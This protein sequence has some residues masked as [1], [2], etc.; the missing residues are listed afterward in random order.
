VQN[1]SKKLREQE[2]KKFLLLAVLTN[3][4][5]ALAQDFNLVDV[6][7][8]PRPL[9]QQLSGSTAAMV[10]ATKL[11]PVTPKV[12]NNIEAYLKAMAIYPK[13]A[14]AS[15]RQ[16][17]KVIKEESAQADKFIPL[18][19]T[20]QEQ[21]YCEDFTLAQEVGLSNCSGTLISDRHILTAGHCADVDLMCE[22]Y[23]WVFDYQKDATNKLPES[24]SQE[25]VYRCKNIVKSINVNI[26]TGIMSQIYQ[27]FFRTDMAIIELDRPV[28]RKPVRLSTSKKVEKDQKVF[29][30]SYPLGM[31]AKVNTEGKVQGG[32]NTAAYFWTDL[33][34]FGGSSGGPIFDEESGEI[35]G[36]VSKGLNTTK[37]NPEKKCVY[38]VSPRDLGEKQTNSNAQMKKILEIIKRKNIPVNIE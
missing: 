3:L 36:V 33:I 21:G 31:P 26:H 9:M 10:S 8:H 20:L 14:P 30:I 1:I 15:Q 7:H 19:Q 38:E 37:T 34:V 6:A 22:E 12:L 28:G 18:Y 11:V 2:M 13:A 35:V 27:T 23:R 24:F 17:L 29:S 25:Q 4:S 5:S 16:I 32:M